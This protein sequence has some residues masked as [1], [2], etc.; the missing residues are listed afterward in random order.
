MKFNYIYFLFFLSSINFT[1]SQTKTEYSDTI[2]LITRN[3]SDGIT[4]ISIHKFANNNYIKTD[5]LHIEMSALLASSTYRDKYIIDFEGQIFDIT[6]NEYLLKFDETNNEKYNLIGIYD[7]KVYFCRNSCS[8]IWWNT[9]KIIEIDTSNC[10]YY[11]DFF[12][13]LFIPIN[14][15]SKHIYLLDGKSFYN[16]HELSLIYYNNI[17]IPFGQTFN[18]DAFNGD[19]NII[20]FLWLSDT[21]FV[22]QTSNGV[23]VKSDTIGNIDT[24][25]AFPKI[26]KKLGMAKLYKDSNNVI[27]YEF[28][29]SK[30]FIYKFHTR[31]SIN[32]EN[33]SYEKYNPIFNEGNFTYTIKKKKYFYYDNNKLLLKKEYF[34]NNDN[35]VKIHKNYLAYVEGYGEKSTIKIY[36]S[37]TKEWISIKNSDRA[38]IIGWL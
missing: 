16:W 18:T 4:K 27:V 13:N 19:D 15:M 23:I 34:I 37:H 35:E 21:T 32:F 12:T 36:N 14:S 10:F 3:Y 24:I 38:S 31:Y 20:P 6:K 2:C 7:N 5:T 17:I 1:F 9:N 29:K 33:K 11:F 22:S 30:R 8:N 26:Q 28:Y 25:F